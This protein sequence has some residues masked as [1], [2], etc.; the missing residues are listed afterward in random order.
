MMRKSSSL[1]VPLSTHALEHV[2]GHGGGVIVAGID[3][4]HGLIVATGIDDRRAPLPGFSPCSGNSAFGARLPEFED[5]EVCANFL[6]LRSL[7][8][9]NGVDFLTMTMRSYP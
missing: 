6:P 8:F 7:S 9:W 3:N 4:K 5:G 2:R 1:T